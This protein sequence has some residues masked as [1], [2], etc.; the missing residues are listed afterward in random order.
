[1]SFCPSARRERGYPWA[2]FH[3]VWCLSIFRKPAETI[4]AVL[5]SDKNNGYFTWRP[6]CIYDNISLDSC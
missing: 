6:V 1:M 3:E 4:Q 5:K 2:E